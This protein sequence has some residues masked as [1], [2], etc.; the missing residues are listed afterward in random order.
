M[1][2]FRAD[3][4]TSGVGGT[5]IFTN[6]GHAMLV[7]RNF[8][9]LGLHSVVNSK[10][11]SLARDRLVDFTGESQLMRRSGDGTSDH[12]HNVPQNATET[13]TVVAPEW[14]QEFVSAATVC[15]GRNR[16]DLDLKRDGGNA[17]LSLSPLYAQEL[18]PLPLNC[19][20]NKISAKSQ[21]GGRSG[22]SAQDI[23]PYYHTTFCNQ[24]LCHPRSLKNC[25]KGNIVIKVEVREMEWNNEYGAYFA[26]VPESGPCIHNPRRGPYLVSGVFTSCSSRCVDPSFLEEMKI[27]LPLMLEPGTDS[28]K[29]RSLSVF[30]TVFKLSFSTRKKWTRRLRG[31]KKLGQKMDE[32]AGDIVGDSTGENES[33]G[34]CHLVQL[35]C[36]HLPISSGSAIIGNGNQDVKLSCVARYPRKELYE[37]GRFKRT[38]YIV[39][40]VV[41]TG[42]GIFSADAPRAE[43]EEATDSESVH[44]GHVLGDNLSSTSATDSMGRSDSIDERKRRQTK[45]KSGS[46]TM[47][48]EVSTF[49]FWFPAGC[50][51]A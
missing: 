29:Q 28:Q 34:S 9:Y 42:R 49:E 15:G 20:S 1:Y 7:M 33:S 13:D 4:S 16:L 5:P 44:S 25:P 23:E 19:V 22:S 17:A 46:E 32:I 8:G 24:L 27:K 36:G 35:A 11:T 48:L 38:T 39:S 2:F 50:S 14:D 30:F 21:R 18:S 37:S 40:E 26:H 41:E 47:S 6:G 3:H 10:S 43:N 31:M 12:E 45:S 51:D